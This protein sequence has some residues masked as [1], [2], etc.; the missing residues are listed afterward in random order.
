MSE[1]THTDTDVDPRTAV[2]RH[3][4]HKPRGRPHRNAEDTFAGVPVNEP[5]PLNADADA[6]ALSRPPEGP[7]ETVPT[8]ITPH[9][10]TLISGDPAATT[11]PGIPADGAVEPLATPTDPAVAHATWLTSH[12]AAAYNE[13]A[14]YPYTSLQYHTLLTAALLDAYRAGYEFGDLHLIATQPSTDGTTPTLQETTDA[15]AALAAD[16]VEP[17]RTVLWTPACALHLTPTPD[18]PAADLG[19]APARSFADTWSRLPSHPID[20]DGAHGWRLLD[21]QLRRIRAWS[22][23]LAYIDDYVRSY[24]PD[25]EDHQ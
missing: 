25:M 6:A 1:S 20:T 11:L 9:R 21:A 16:I 15:E 5:V 2:Y 7:D 17:H 3:D 23:A 14:Y 10:L 18:G 19:P 8:H 12:T 4:I 22:T 24:G 13:T